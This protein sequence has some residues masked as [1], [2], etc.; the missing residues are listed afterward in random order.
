M[1]TSQQLALFSQPQPAAKRSPGGHLAEPLTREERR[2][3]GRFYAENVRL[4]RKFAA[5]LRRTYGHCVTAEDINSCCDLAF[6]KACRAWDPEK[7]QFSTIFWPLARG[8][9][10]H[11]IRG[12]NWGLAAPYRAREMGLRARRLID[13][14]MSAELICRE[15]HCSA[16]DLRLALVATM[17]VGH[18]AMGFELHSCNRPTPWEA[19][20]AAES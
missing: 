2:R 16:D 18:D 19:L 4:V 17:P 13:I 14:G 12:S 11:F 3:F 20:E 9:V 15:L 10:L 8:E 6:L 5:N 7:G 1:S